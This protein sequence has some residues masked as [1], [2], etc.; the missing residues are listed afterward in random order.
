[1]TK[2]ISNKL[3]TLL[4]LG[5][6]TITTAS[7]IFPVS[8]LSRNNCVNIKVKSNL[9]LYINGVKYKLPLNPSCPIKPEFKPNNNNNN[10]TK[11]NNNINNDN[12]KPV[13]KP[14]NDNNTANFSSYQKQ[15]LD[16]VNAERTKED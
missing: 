1:M 10:A 5:V 9:Y 3:K 12:N 13:E 16:L 11:P 2:N 7:S 4:T 6:V 14:N 8:A 15:V